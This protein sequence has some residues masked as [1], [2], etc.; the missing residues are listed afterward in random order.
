MAPSTKRPDPHAQILFPPMALASC[1]AFAIVRD[2]RGLMLSGAD[3]LN[4]F[5][6]S[7]LIT[8]TVV[9]NGQIHMSNALCDLQ[10]LSESDPL[11]RVFV[12]PPQPGPIVSWSP[13][14]VRAV[15]IGFFPNAWRKLGGALNKTDLPRAIGAAAD[16][17]HSAEDLYA[18]WTSFCRLLTEVWKEAKTDVSLP[19]W[20]GGARLTDWVRH[21]VL[22][23]AMSGPGR[24][25]RAIERRLKRWTGHSR[26]SLEFF[27]QVDHLHGLVHQAKNQT[28]AEIAYDGA[29][30][31]QAHMGRAVKRA[32]GFSPVK[33]NKL[34]E[35][36]EAFW[37]YRLLGERF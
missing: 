13:G 4:Y 1:V 36:E 24:S 26:Q 21:V 9:L 35:T 3:R 12:S 2:T 15:T 33:L 20:R 27:A 31:D 32:T 16:A 34:I 11:P 37:C 10:T 22:Q 28:A 5:P 6:A 23:S 30:S 7:P 8:L 14:A 29:Y 18:G 19:Q 17:V 25:A